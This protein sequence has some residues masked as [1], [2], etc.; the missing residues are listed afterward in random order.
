MANLSSGL[1]NSCILPVLFV[2]SSD[3]VRTDDIGRGE[4]ANAVMSDMLWL[5]VPSREASSGELATS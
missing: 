5:V 4:M 3:D 1:C 2:V